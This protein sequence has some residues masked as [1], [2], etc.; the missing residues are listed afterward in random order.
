MQNEGPGGGDRRG[1]GR[2]LRAAR[3]AGDAE[4]AHRLVPAAEERRATGAPFEAAGMQMLTVHG[5]TREQ[6][7]KG[8]RIRHHRRREGRRAHRAGGGQWRHHQPERRVRCWR[9][10]A[11]MPSWSAARP[12]A[13]LD[14]P[15]DGALPGHGRALPGPPLV[16]EVRRLLL[17]HLKTTTSLYG[18]ASG[19]R[20]ARKHISPGTCAP[21]PAARPC[22]NASTP[23]RDCAAQWQAVR[24]FRRLG[25]GWTGCPA[26]DDA[27]PTTRGFDA[28]PPTTTRM[29]A[30]KP[31]SYFRDL[32]G[33]DPDGVYDMVVRLVERPA[34]GSGDEPGRQ[35]P[36]PRRRM[37]GPERNT[38]RK[39]TLHKLL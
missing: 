14:L 7:Y 23:W 33:R 1:R 6:G 24:D 35:Q 30:R 38:L 4:D 8:R 27:D 29:R 13:A 31:A 9:R 20:S 10:P 21:C 26:S 22:A 17:E 34:A 11:P 25:A 3:R 16:A 19:V 15:R 32:D 5:R 28:W 39:L 36:V 2:R 37:A 12:R 18:Q